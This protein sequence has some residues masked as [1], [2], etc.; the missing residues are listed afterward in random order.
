MSWIIL[1]ESRLLAKIAVSRTFSVNKL[2]SQT[3]TLFPIA[4]FVSHISRICE[5][6]FIIY[7]MFRANIHSFRWRRKERACLDLWVHPSLAPINV[8]AV[9]LTMNSSLWMKQ[10]KKKRKEEEKVKKKRDRW[11]TTSKERNIPG[12]EYARFKGWNFIHEDAF[13]WPFA[14]MFTLTNAQQ[15]DRHVCVRVF[16]IHRSSDL[17]CRVCESLLL[18]GTD[19]I[20]RHYVPD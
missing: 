13:A 15:T 16:T 8:L 4:T 17:S 1:R 10:K 14:C 12:K 5:F 7:V 19:G 11:K 3:I 6:Y 2:C 9:R 18:R 20:K